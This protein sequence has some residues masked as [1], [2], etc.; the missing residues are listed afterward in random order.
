MTAHESPTSVARETNKSPENLEASLSQALTDFYDLSFEP[1]FEAM[2]A[3]RRIAPDDTDQPFY[4]QAAAIFAADRAA[5]LREQGQDEK[6]LAMTELFAATPAFIYDN[7]TLNH[8]GK[9]AHRHVPDGEFKDAK[10]G[11]S[12]FNSLLR[13]TASLWPELRASQLQSNLLNVANISLEDP[14]AQ[15]QADKFI[16][17]CVRGAQH[18]TAFDQLLDVTGRDHREATVDEDLHGIDKVVARPDGSED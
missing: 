11:A 14:A 16:N 12:Y 17:A 5:K 15:R 1:D 8:Y 9:N 7:M 10:A 6:Q 13:H 18:E 4:W 2:C 3:D